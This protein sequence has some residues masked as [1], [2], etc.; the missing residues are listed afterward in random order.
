MAVARMRPA[1][2][3]A[4]AVAAALIAAVVVLT[5]DDAPGPSVPSGIGATTTLGPTRALFGDPIDA[6]LVVYVDPAEVDPDSVKVRATFAPYRA[7]APAIVRSSADGVVSLRYRFTLTC[8]RNECLPPMRGRREFRFPRAVVTARRIGGKLALVSSAWDRVRVSGRILP[9]EVAQPTWESHEARVSPATFRF[10]PGRLAWLLDALAAAL[11][12]AG[13]ALLAWNALPAVRRALTRDELAGLES[14]ERALALLRRARRQGEA[15]EQRKA[16]DRLAR[17][18][19]TD[20][21]DELAVGARHL[22]WSQPD[23]VP[24]DVDELA[25]RVAGRGNGA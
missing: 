16:L 20:G 9:E 7:L 6:R 11:A 3:A 14:I 25:G 15:N 8:L 12:L 4:A 1:L 13:V 10:A 17:E 18:L 2:V 24:D 23:P 5:R 21:D 22:A 19:R